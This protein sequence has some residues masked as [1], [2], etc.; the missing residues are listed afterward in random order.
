MP[1][2]QGSVV[3]VHRCAEG[4]PH[5]DGQIVRFDGVRHR[6]GGRRGVPPAVVHDRPVLVLGDLPVDFDGFTRSGA[7]H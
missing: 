6:R 2:V 5:T 3:G 1:L 7:V 4:I